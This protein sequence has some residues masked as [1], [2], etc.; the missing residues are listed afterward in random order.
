[1][2]EVGFIVLRHVNN[3][4]SNQYW[5][6]C[7]QCIRKFYSENKILIIDDNSNYDFT[8]QYYGDLK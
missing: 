1:M 7:I 3:K 4:L 8:L 2:P 5:I 6:H